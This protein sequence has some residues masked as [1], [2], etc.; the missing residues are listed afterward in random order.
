MKALEKLLSVAFSLAIFGWIAA[1]MHEGFHL[2]VSKSLGVG[3]RIDLA[4]GGYGTF[5][6]D[7]PLPLGSDVLMRLAGGVGTGLVFLVLWALAAFQ[8]KHT[9][10]ELDDASALLLVALMQ[11]AY[12]PI[13]AFWV[14]GPWWVITASALA[15]VG[16][17]GVVYGK[18]LMRWIAE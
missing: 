12:A 11:F 18:R 5:Q 7:G 13:D 3:G 10:W 4:W 9:N 2:L 16:G 14:G 6:P 1:P 8:L 17:T 15:A